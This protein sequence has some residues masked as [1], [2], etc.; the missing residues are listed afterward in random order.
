MSHPTTDS[1]DLLILHD[2]LTD[3]LI[4]HV[5]D[6]ILDSK[7]YKAYPAFNIQLVK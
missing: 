1:F 3:C 5:H 4:L 6:I 2:L 7:Q